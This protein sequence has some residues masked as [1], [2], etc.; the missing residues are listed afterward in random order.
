MNFPIYCLTFG[1]LLLIL[2]SKP[3]G[4][5]FRWIRLKADWESI[6]LGILAASVSAAIGIVVGISWAQNG[7]PYLG[8]A[9][10]ALKTAFEL[11]EGDSDSFRALAA[12]PG[13]LAVGAKLLSV[14]IPVSAAGTLIVFV[15]EHF[16]HILFP[17][18]KY[19]IFSHLDQRS[20]LLARD[21]QAHDPG[22]AR[23]L[24]LRCRKKEV[25]SDLLLQLQALPHQ[26]YPLT[27]TDLLIRHMG[28]RRK[29]LQF[30]FLG[31]NTDEN[32]DRMDQFLDAIASRSLF[33]NVFPNQAKRTA[34]AENS[35]YHQELYLLS[36]TPS[37][38]MLMDHLRAKLCQDND[39]A[40]PRKKVFRSTEL[41][42]LDRYRAVSYRLLQTVP[43]YRSAQD[44]ENQV[45]LLGF[46]R[47]GQAIY[48][49]AFSFHVMADFRTEFHICDKEINLRYD[50]MLQH[51]SQTE[52]DMPVRKYALDVES[53]NIAGLLEKAEKP[54]SFTYIVIALG[55]DERN[56][57]AASSLKR[58]YRKCFWE[59]KIRNFPAICVNVEDE[60]K[61][62]YAVSMFHQMDHALREDGIKIESHVF[63]TNRQT[64][65]ISTLTPRG[66]WIASQKLHQKLSGKDPTRMPFWSEYERRSSLASVCHAGY[67][68][69]SVSDP[70]TGE[71]YDAAFCTQKDK[72]I[73]AE[74]QRWMC[75]VRS[76]GMQGVPLSTVN[77]YKKYTRSHVDVTGKLTPCLV[78]SEQLPSLYRDLVSRSHLPGG[79]YPFQ[80]RDVMVVKHAWCLHKEISDWYSSHS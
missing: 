22:C 68:V 33:W 37:A 62:S 43:L 58:Y 29:K 56:I 80:D 42:L 53:S 77:A 7:G 48:R 13:W 18:R 65:S 54:V 71:E 40:Q 70:C 28:L 63:G 17:S 47:V 67:H 61:S 36:E 34:A 73:K 35:E 69:A 5:L 39:P 45:L 51:L 57:Q 19:I 8:A 41:R 1:C 14:I 11:L 78:E 23:F 24:F 16:P 2:C 31:E 50:A 30:Y 20:V 74:H 44:G 25:D 15:L 4:K 52:N 60:I 49:A 38:P 32:F 10:P 79:L 21:I 9:F 6:F 66:A 76:E 64:F 46:G 27:E 3:L 12:S 55:D 72:L 59:G 75:Y 26:L